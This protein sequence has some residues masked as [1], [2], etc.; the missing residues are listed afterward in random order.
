MARLHGKQYLRQVLDLSVELSRK[1]CCE[2]IG[3]GSSSVERN[4]ENVEH[5]SLD[6][7]LA[8]ELEILARAVPLKF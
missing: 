8:L 4:F 1:L 3:L 7:A 2:Y 6:L 5:I